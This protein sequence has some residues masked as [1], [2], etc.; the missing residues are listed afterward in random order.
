MRIL[1]ACPFCGGDPVIEVRS[2]YFHDA[3]VPE[4]ENKRYVVRC[5]KC[6][7]AV[8]HYVS[9]EKAIMWWNTRTKTTEVELITEILKDIY[10]ICVDYDG[11]YN[12]IEGLR[13]TID[14]I[15]NMAVNHLRQTK[16]K[17][18]K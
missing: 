7:V 16:R 13:K 3:Y 6:M 12:S 14:D 17:E 2:N 8:S 18:S 1:K 11:Y 4:S 10:G 9:A 15:K 5:K